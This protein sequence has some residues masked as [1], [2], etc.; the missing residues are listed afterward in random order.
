MPSSGRRSLALPGFGGSRARLLEQ[1]GERLVARLRPELVDVDARRHLVHAL[2]VPDDLVEHRRMCA[3]PTKTAPRRRAPPSPTPRAP[4][5]PRIEYSSSEPCALTAKRRTA[6][7]AHGAAEED[8]VRED[9]VGRREL[10]QRRGVR[11]DVRARAP[12]RE[13][14]GAAAA[15]APRSGRARRRAAARRQSGRTTARR[16]GR[17]AP[18]AAPGR[19]R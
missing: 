6:R 19:R 11:L 10:A 18:D 14:P 3:E 15:R 16:R 17:T 13:S 12:A 8:V 9:E 7:R 5:R 2:D 1:A 4:G